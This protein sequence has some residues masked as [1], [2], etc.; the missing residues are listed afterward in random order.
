VAVVFDW[1]SRLV[2]LSSTFQLTPYLSGLQ[3]TVIMVTVL[4]LG[5]IG[6]RARTLKLWHAFFMLAFYPLSLALVAFLD[7]YLGWH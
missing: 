3:V 6:S 2:I 7:F 5:I 1:S 4:T